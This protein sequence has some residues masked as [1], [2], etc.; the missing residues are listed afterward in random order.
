M[1]M[2]LPMMFCMV[3]AYLI[4]SI[5]P[6]ILAGKIAGKGD[7]RQY[8]SHGTGATNVQRT[9][10]TTAGIIVFFLDAF[11]GVIAVFVAK[12]VFGM[13]WPDWLGGII[14]E[15]FLSGRGAFLQSTFTLLLAISAILG[16]IFP[17]YY[18][19]KGGK[20]VATTFAILMVADWRVGLLAFAVFLA[21]VFLTRYISLGSI[22]GAIAYFVIAFAFPEPIAPWHIGF[23]DLLTFAGVVVAIFVYTHRTNIRRLLAGKENKISFKKKEK[24]A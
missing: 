1:I 20:G 17:A 2:I 23:G 14:L 16:H 6:G 13:F 4:G 24:T 9:L 19:F 8:G 12:W 3:V 5:S 11:K 18:R 7:I 10:G 22:T 15:G 21:V